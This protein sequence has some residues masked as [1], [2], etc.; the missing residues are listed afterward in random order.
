[1]DEASVIRY[2]RE[3]YPDADVLTAAGTTFF[4]CDP[5]KHWPNF[6]TIVTRDEDG[7]TSLLDRPG[8]YRLNIG[9]TKASFDSLVGAIKDPDYTELD[10]LM[11]HP[12]Y[13]MQ[14]WVAVLNPSEATFE[15]VVRPLLEEAHERIARARRTSRAP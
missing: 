13:A 9:L 1:M 2:I 5:E 6:A 11:P 8:V 3:T 10:R 4:S 12:V 15:S 7:A 14:H